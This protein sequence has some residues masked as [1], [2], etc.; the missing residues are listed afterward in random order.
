MNIIAHKNIANV[1]EEELVKRYSRLRYKEDWDEE[2]ERCDIPVMLH[3]GQCEW[4][5]E[6]G[7]YHDYY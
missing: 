3:I 2:C 1:S 7:N 6:P 4:K 5:R